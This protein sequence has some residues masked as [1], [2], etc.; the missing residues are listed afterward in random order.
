[1]DKLIIR[2]LVTALALLAISNLD[3]G[4]TVESFYI[5]LI[6][7]L[8]L[9]VLNALVRPILFILTFPI[10]ILSLGLFI[11][12]INASLFYFATTFIEGFDV[13]SFWTA[14][15]GSILLSLVSATINRLMP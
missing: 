3:L 2:I 6:A 5:A 14:L 11:F 15:L 10:T 12:V 13:T 9:S 8:V 1:M 7:V 4:I